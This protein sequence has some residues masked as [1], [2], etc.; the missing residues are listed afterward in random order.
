MKPVLSIL[1][2]ST[3]ALPF[4]AGAATKNAS[5][6]SVGSNKNSASKV[7]LGVLIASSQAIGQSATGLSAIVL[8]NQNQWFQVDLVLP[9][10]SPFAMMLGGQ[11][12][13][14][15]ASG[16]AAGFHVGGGLGFGAIS[17]NGVASAGASITGLAG[18]HVRIPEVDN[19]L[20]SV[21]AGP[22]LNFSGAGANFA[23]AFLGLSAHYLF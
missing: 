1:I 10:V 7:G 14:T 23:A 5:S 15:V 17:T 12:K 8:L 2:A 19:L 16:R 21:D 22:T 6:A 4:S 18:I 20:F 3:L 13:T 11:F 9:S